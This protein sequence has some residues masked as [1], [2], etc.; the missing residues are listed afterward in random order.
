MSF[1]SQL[2][3][4]GS[5][6][7]SPAAFGREA[8]PPVARTS[9]SPANSSMTTRSA[10]TPRR[11]ARTVH[12]AARSKAESIS[13]AESEADGAGRGWRITIARW[14]GD[15]KGALETRIPQ[16]LNPT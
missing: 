2:N 3:I 7:S 4:P 15:G 10:R 1:R 11:V 9:V 16:W 14:V 5:Q 13:E 8:L 12:A 6:R